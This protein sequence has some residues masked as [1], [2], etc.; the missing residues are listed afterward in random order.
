MK[1]ITI[2][3]KLALLCVLLPISFSLP[4]CSNSDDDTKTPTNEKGSGSTGG[5]KGPSLT[6][7]ETTTIN[8][9][10]VPVSDKDKTST[11]LISEAYTA[12][13][14]GDYNKTLSKF[15]SAYAKEQYPHK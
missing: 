13:N 11:N 15:R 7:E 9:I 10:D 14:A 4:S 5:E 6:E 2:L 3:K 1:K 12:L 8:G